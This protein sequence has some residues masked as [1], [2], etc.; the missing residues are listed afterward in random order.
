VRGG[1]GANTGAGFASESSCHEL[2]QESA[3]EIVE[4]EGANVKS[5]L[6]T[7]WRQ[8]VED[9]LETLLPEEDAEPFHLHRAMRYAV[10]G[11]GKRIRPVLVYASGTALGV[12]PEKLDHAAA[13]VEMVHAYSLV[14]DDLPAMDDDDLRRGRPTCHIAFDEATAIL[15]GDTLLALAFE[16]LAAADLVA[17]E[18]LRLVQLLAEASG[19][20]GMAGGQVMDLQATGRLLSA[21]AL[22]AMHQK[23]TGALLRACVLMGVVPAQ[24]EASVLDG[25]EHYATAIGLAF[26]V[27]DDILDVEGVTERIG[28]PQGSDQ[29]QKK[30]TYVSLFGLAGAKEELRELHQ[31]AHK[32]LERLDSRADPLREIADFIV[33]RDH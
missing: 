19:A 11:G 25:L 22:T 14:H 28:K 27:Q 16:V 29:A 17:T 21:D 23:K 20:R 5:S 4:T 13:A 18:R 31:Q 7:A 33:Q 8:R 32:S 3:S 2:L 24:P 1:S 30:S 9:A 26:Q 15:A 12:E 6:S 10:L